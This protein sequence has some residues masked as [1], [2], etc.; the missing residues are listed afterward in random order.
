MDLIILEF[1]SQR[2]AYSFDKLSHLF[3]CD[4]W[5]RRFRKLRNL[6]ISKRDISLLNIETFHWWHSFLLLIKLKFHLIP[7]ALTGQ[8]GFV[9]ERSLFQPWHIHIFLILLCFRSVTGFVSMDS[10]VTNCLWIFPH[11]EVFD[12]FWLMGIFYIWFIVHFFVYMH[13][14]VLYFAWI[15]IGIGFIIKIF[16]ETLSDSSSFGINL[17]LLRLQF[18]SWRILKFGEGAHQIFLN[19]LFFYF[20]MSTILLNTNFRRNWIVVFTDE[21]SWHGRI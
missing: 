15:R 20:F 4:I 9:I 2:V 8:R 12:A 10:R 18:F 16:E 1:N 14:A 21:M 7:S 19:F 11:P 5:T 3:N 6:N 17:L 13:T